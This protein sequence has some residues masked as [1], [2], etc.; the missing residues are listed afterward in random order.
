MTYDVKNANRSEKRALKLHKEAAAHT[1]VGDFI[2]A[3][4]KVAAAYGYH[5]AA[6]HYAEGNCGK[7]CKAE[8]KANQFANGQIQ[9]P[10]SLSQQS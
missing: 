8:H 9:F 10:K 6:K 3:K 5:L 2:S 1:V 7:A 4:Q